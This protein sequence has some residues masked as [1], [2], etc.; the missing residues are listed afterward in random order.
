MS[1]K[2]EYSPQDANRY[3]QCNRKRHT[4]PGRWILAAILI[5]T[6][7]WVRL[8]GVPDYFIPGEPEKTK[9]AATEMVNR[10]QKGTSVTEAVT[11]FCKDILYDA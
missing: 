8:N 3:P 10:L 5:A 9:A 2:I 6:V 11:A 7:F 1:Y 4:K